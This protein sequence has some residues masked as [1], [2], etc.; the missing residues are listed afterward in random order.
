MNP[1]YL[2]FS[3]RS[4]EQVRLEAGYEITLLTDVPCHLWLRWTNL[5]PWTH[6]RSITRRGL[7]ILKDPYY[8]FDVYNDLEQ[9]EPLDTIVHTFTWLDWEVCFTRWFYF[10]GN[11]DQKAVA[12]TSCLFK[13]HFP[14]PGEEGLLY[15]YWKGTWSASIV[16]FDARHGA[17]FQLGYPF[18]LTKIGVRLTVSPGHGDESVAWFIM[19]IRDTPVANNAL[20]A[21]IDVAWLLNT[22]LPQWPNMGWRYF[23]FSQIPMEAWHTYSYWMASQFH[24]WSE[25]RYRVSS[26]VEPGIPD[27]YRFTRWFDYLADHKLAISDDWT[28]NVRIYGIPL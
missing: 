6:P 27:H 26:R 17:C 1:G 16:W 18:K 23:T 8:C 3:I 21:Y 7:T 12:S 4:I 2:N 28:R 13:K 24:T 9:E 19:E 11:I 22:G 14:A 10:H 20:P 25:Y 15:E 5:E